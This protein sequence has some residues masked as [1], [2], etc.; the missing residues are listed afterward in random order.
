MDNSDGTVSTI[1]RTE[2]YQIERS[3]GF[4]TKDRIEWV[5]ECEYRLIPVKIKDKLGQM[6]NAILTFTILEIKQYS[7]VVRVSGC[8]DPFDV[9]VFEK[10]HVEDE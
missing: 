5:S 6:G 7:Y 1:K 8:G 3:K 4:M 10:G 2:K 9:E